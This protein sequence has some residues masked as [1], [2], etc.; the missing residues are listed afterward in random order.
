MAMLAI[1]N[2][3]F[4]YGL[5]RSELTFLWPLISGVALMLVLI[6]NYHD[7]AMTIA[8]ILFVSTGVILSGT[9]LSKLITILRRPVTS[10]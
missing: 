8:Q 1:C 3:V 7:S 9:I 6:I 10:P 2:V 5:A 4:S